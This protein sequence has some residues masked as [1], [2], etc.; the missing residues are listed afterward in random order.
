MQMRVITLARMPINFYPAPGMVLICDFRGTIAPEICKIRPV[1]VISAPVA[2]R[3]GLSTIV[4]LS[5]S[6]PRPVRH[7]H[8]L[9]RNPPLS[10]AGVEVWAKCD[11]VMSVSH[12]RLSR[13]RVREHR[14]EILWVTTAE[15]KEIRLAAARS[16]GVDFL[17][18]QF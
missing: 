14:F 2:R 5:T 17:D 16:F 12:S 18:R 13:V 1:V 8:I 3:Y 11:L 4:P 10:S 9:L 7:Y 6:R 15:L